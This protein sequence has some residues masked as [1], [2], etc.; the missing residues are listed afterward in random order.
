MRPV[1]PAILALVALAGLA[2]RAEDPPG[3][4]PALSRK[5]TEGE[6]IAFELHAVNRGRFRTVEYSARAQAR[7]RRGATGFFEE[8]QWSDLVVDGTLVPLAAAG[9]F[10]QRLSLSPETALTVPNVGQI[11]PELVGPALDLLNFYSD[12]RLAIRREGLAKAGDRK[13]IP[14]NRPNSWADGRAIL[15]GEDTMDFDVTLESIDTAERK[16][17]VVV[18]HVAP[19]NPAIKIAA[20]WMRSP[21]ARGAN[22]WTQVGRYPPGK[23]TAAIGSELIE[24]AVEVDLDGGRILAASM[25]NPLET[26]ERECEDAEARRCGEPSRHKVLRTIELKAVAPR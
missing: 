16:A 10:R 20:D 9:A 23:Y 17:R 22:N 8:F 1:F 4:P 18:R 24:V 13:L 12:L 21:V 5:Y 25:T 3:A 26:I 19:D 2:A 7:V 14:H 11:P 6:V 15:I